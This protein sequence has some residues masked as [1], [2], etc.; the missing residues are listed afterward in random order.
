MSGLA[1]EHKQLVQSLYRQSL[2][3]SRDWINRRDLW[4]TKALEIRQEFD[5]HKNITDKHEIIVRRR[6][7]VQCRIN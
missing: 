4:R 3:L 1:V 6:R 7:S 5:E 2:R